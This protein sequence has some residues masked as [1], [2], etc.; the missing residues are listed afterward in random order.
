MSH[1]Q[2]CNVLV[3]L[4]DQTKALIALVNAH[5]GKLPQNLTTLDQVF[6]HYG[7]KA[8]TG[9]NTVLSYEKIRDMPIARG[10]G[11]RIREL[12]SQ[13][14]DYQHLHTTSAALQAGPSQQMASSTQGREQISWAN[15]HDHRKFIIKSSGK[16]KFWA[17]KSQP[18]T[19]ELVKDRSG[20]CFRLSCISPSQREFPSSQRGNLS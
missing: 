5:D 12:A 19:V 7:L 15:V 11:W 1:D 4:V 17:R 6:S 3:T 14:S 20:I 13:L 16:Y 8:T 2:I 18:L 9:P 10:T